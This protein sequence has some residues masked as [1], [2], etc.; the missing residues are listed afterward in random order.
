[1]SIVEEIASIGGYVIADD[2]LDP[3]P[4]CRPGFNIQPQGGVIHWT[5]NLG[6]KANAKANR[7][8]WNGLRNQYASAHLVGDSERILAALPYL[9]GQAEMGYHVGADTYK[10]N[11][12]GAYPNRTLLGY[13]MAVNKDGDFRESYKR[14]VWGMAHLAHLYGWIPR[15]DIVRHYDITGKDCPLMFLDLIWDDDHCHAY[16]WSDESITWMRENL[17]IDGIQGD[18]LFRKYI[19]DVAEIVLILDE[20]GFAVLNEM[21]ARIEALQDRINVLEARDNLPEVPEWAEKAV[22]AAKEAGMID[23]DVPVTG[24]YDFYRLITVLHRKSII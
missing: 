2:F 6:W 7:N 15:T 22:C 18:A 16:G 12:F 10:T 23:T 9:P 20:G 1:M 19:D 8:Y 3:S 11:R 5:A 14:A 21:K 4:W 17:H 24:S 13:E